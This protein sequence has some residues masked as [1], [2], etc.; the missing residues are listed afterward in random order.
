MVTI[1]YYIAYM[2]TT[3]PRPLL[4]PLISS[5]LSPNVCSPIYIP[6]SATKSQLPKGEVSAAAQNT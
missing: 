4:S 6:Y 5:H 2:S 3:D 1:L